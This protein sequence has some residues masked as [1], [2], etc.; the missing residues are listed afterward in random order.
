MVEGGSLVVRHR[1]LDDAPLTP[2]FRDA[3]LVRG[4]LAAF[5]RDGS[6]AVE[7]FTLSDGRVWNVRFRR[8]AP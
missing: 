2:T 7:G 1:K 8:G 5:T 4:A 3:F 6:G